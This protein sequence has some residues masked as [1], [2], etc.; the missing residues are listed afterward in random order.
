MPHIFR[1]ELHKLC[2]YT[3]QDKFANGVWR[4]HTTITTKKSIILKLEKNKHKRQNSISK[5]SSEKIWLFNGNLLFLSALNWNDIHT[6]KTRF[7]VIFWLLTERSFKRARAHSLVRSLFGWL[8]GP[9]ARLLSSTHS[10]TSRTKN[11]TKQTMKICFETNFR[12]TTVFFELFRYTSL[13]HILPVI[14]TV[15]EYFTSSQY[16]RVA[17]LSF[18][19]SLYSI[20]L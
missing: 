1:I 20:W 16:R 5:A 12:S 19:F 18:G 10:F 15:L 14:I 13:L 8:V 11:R 6:P 4:A 17:L 7:K 2:V 9:F 3:R